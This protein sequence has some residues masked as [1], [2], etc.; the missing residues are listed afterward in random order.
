MLTHAKKRLSY[1]ALVIK[2][3]CS[4]SERVFK[5][6]NLQCYDDFLA[7]PKDYAL[8]IGLV[9]FFKFWCQ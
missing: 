8:L 2:S 3:V 9:L 1:D 5:K 7:I 4:L 6:N